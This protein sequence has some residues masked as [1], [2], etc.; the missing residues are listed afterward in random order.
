MD[1]SRSGVLLRDTFKTF[2]QS[3]PLD[4]FDPPIHRSVIRPSP[5]RHAG[6]SDDWLDE[7]ELRTSYLNR[8]AH[9]PER[10]SVRFLRFNHETVG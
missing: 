8:R 2:D 5:G 10:A 4:A 7:M 1:S 3:P 6:I 9:K